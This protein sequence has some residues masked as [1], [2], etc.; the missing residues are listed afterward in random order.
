[1]TGKPGSYLRA[2]IYATIALLIPISHDLSHDSL[3][4]A[5]FVRGAIAALVVL[6]AYVDQTASLVD[7]ESQVAQAA[8]KEV[9]DE[10]SPKAIAP[11]E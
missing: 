9:A 10:V 8:V 4:F 5:T 3:S 2:A 7:V 1:M 11:K 6:R